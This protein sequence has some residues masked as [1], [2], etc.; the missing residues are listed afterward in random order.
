MRFLD[1]FAHKQSCCYPEHNERNEHHEHNE[2]GKQ[3]QH[4]ETNE[5]NKHN[6]HNEHTE[7]NERRTYTDRH[8]CVCIHCLRHVQRSMPEW[9]GGV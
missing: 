5:Y 3:N 8:E 2:H 9:A 6:E 4:N 1:T 7:H